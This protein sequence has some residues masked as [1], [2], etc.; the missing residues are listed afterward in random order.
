MNTRVRAHV[1]TPIGGEIDTADLQGVGLYRGKEIK[2]SRFNDNFEFGVHD[3]ADDQDGKSATSQKVELKSDF[4]KK[5]KNAF[6]DQQENL[7]DFDD[8]ANSPDFQKWSMR[9]SDQLIGETWES[10]KWKSKE[11]IYS[12]NPDKDYRDHKVKFGSLGR[13]VSGTHMPK[14]ID[15]NGVYYDTMYPTDCWNTENDFI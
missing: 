15:S 12:V 2:K 4:Q 1:S 7:P 8:F 11:V 14:C 5:E 10:Y 9:N 3:E 13:I 6:S